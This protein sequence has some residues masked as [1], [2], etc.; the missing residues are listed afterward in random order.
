M[1]DT[2]ILA[3]MTRVITIKAIIVDSNKATGV[4]SLCQSLTSTFTQYSMFSIMLLSSLA[5]IMYKVPVS[6][7]QY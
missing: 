5:I 3:T 6:R 7:I 2:S 1:E 4:T